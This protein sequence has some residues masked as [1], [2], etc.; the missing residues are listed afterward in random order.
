[1]SGGRHGIGRRDAVPTRLDRLAMAAACLHDL[2][3]VSLVL[4]GPLR[5]QHRS[6]HGLFS[7]FREAKS[8][9]LRE[10][11]EAIKLTL[12]RYLRG[13]AQL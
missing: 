2:A 6:H 9:A 7:V 10:V 13:Q 5:G 4:L 8:T 11:R 12:N 1:V 3:Q